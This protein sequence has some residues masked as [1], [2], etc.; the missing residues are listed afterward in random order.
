LLAIVATGFAEK[1]LT[2]A[3]GIVIHG[4][5]LFIAN[6]SIHRFMLH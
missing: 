1:G 5:D 6:I 4:G 2:K 3:I